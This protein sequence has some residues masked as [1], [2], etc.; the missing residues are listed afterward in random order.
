MNR[1]VLGLVAVAAVIVIGVGTWL[2]SRPA[3]TPGPPIPPVASQQSPNATAPIP[4][5]TPASATP[6]ATPAA[7]TVPA[8]APPAAP[9]ELAFERLDIDTSKPIA[10]ACLIFSHKLD[11]AAQYGEYLV[12]TPAVKPALRVDGKSLCLAGL[13][14]GATY[15][16]ELRAGLPAADGLKL[17]ASQKVDVALRNR[18]PLVAFRDGMILPRDNAAGVPITS[19]NVA[20]LTIKL[21]RVPDRL[22]SL[23]GAD[24]FAQHQVYGWTVQGWENQ[25]AATIWQGQMDVT[26]KANET[27][28]TLF[29]LADV[30]KD[31]KPGAYILVADDAAQKESA[32]GDGDSYSRTRAVQ[33]VIDSDIALTSFEGADGLNVFAR[34][35]AHATPIAGLKLSLIALN[36]DVLANLVTDADGRGHFDPGLTRGTGAVSPSAVMAYGADGDF[37]FADLARPAF[38]LSDR[39]VAGRALPGP[40]DGFVYTDRGIYRARETVNIVALLRDRQANAMPGVPVTIIARRPDGAVY[41]RDTIKD[42]GDGAVHEALTLSATVPHGHWSVDAYLDPKGDFHRPRR[43]RRAGFHPAAAQGDAER[44][45]RVPEAGRSRAFRRRGALPLWRAGGGSRR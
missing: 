41:R 37:T 14:F 26:A 43:I 5:A 16:A 8:P 44:H 15:S 35:L 17:P 38:D 18:P 28:T 3:P 7:A 22:L 2:G 42:Q 9:P 30:L 31:K 20:K 6:T 12:L 33:W 27:V 11:A 1:M 25:K 21:M 40:V 34:S 39:G 19:I 45:A 4:A 36:N 23:I 24:T 29:P 10:E 32:S 13:A